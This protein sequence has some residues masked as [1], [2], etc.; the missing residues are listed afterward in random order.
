MLADIFRHLLAQQGQR[1]LVHPVLG[2]PAHQCRQR[3]FA[4]GKQLC[5]LGTETVFQQLE[6][7]VGQVL[8]LL[9]R[10][11]QRLID[12]VQ[13]VVQFLHPAQRQI[14]RE[15]V[16]AGQQR[17]Q[18][19]VFF[20][21]APQIALQFLRGAGGEEL[22]HGGNKVEQIIQLGAVMRDRL[23]PAQ[24]RIDHPAGLHFAQVPHTAGSG[25]QQHGSVPH[26]TGKVD[27][28]GVPFVDLFQQLRDGLKLLFLVIHAVRHFDHHQPFFRDAHPAQR[29]AEIFQRGAGAAVRHFHHS[30]FAHRLAAQCQNAV[31]GLLFLYQ[32]PHRALVGLGLVVRVFRAHI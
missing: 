14:F 4:G 18:H 24:L 12:L 9:G 21:L 17:V 19:R 10:L 26:A 28:K 11:F 8:A 1:L 15:L 16:D 30:F 27:G 20:A 29:I 6:E 13:I 22:V 25:H 3:L 23:F 32:V 5:K 7:Q 2:A 31:R